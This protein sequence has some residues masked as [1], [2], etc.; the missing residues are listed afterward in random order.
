MKQIILKN[1]DTYVY[2]DSSNIKNALRTVGVNLDFIKL[3]KYLD[4]T[5][6]YLKTVKYFEGIDKRDTKKLAKFKKLEKAGYQLHTLLRKTYFNS[7]KYKTFKCKEC[8]KKNTVEILKKSKN[9]KSN[10]DV[11][12]C[13]ELMGDL[14]NIKKLFHV[15]VFSCDGDFSEMI[16]NVLRKNKNAHVSVFATPF[17][18]HNNYLSIRLKQLERIER[19]Y[20]VNIMNIRDRIKK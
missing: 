15:I 6:K 3:Y 1:L 13:S 10:V 14:L 7:A 12:L 2:L 8:N 11:Y 5:Y 18:K 20:L 19:Y 9:L 17:T 4:T 16:E